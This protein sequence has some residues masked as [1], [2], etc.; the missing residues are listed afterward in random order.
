LVTIH[1]GAV[2]YRNENWKLVCEPRIDRS[3]L[4][5]WDL[6]Q[7]PEDWGELNQ[8]AR[9][10]RSREMTAN[11]R[12]KEVTFWARV[13]NMYQSPFSQTVDLVLESPADYTPE[14]YTFMMSREA[15]AEVS[16]KAALEQLAAIPAT[17]PMIATGKIESCN[18]GFA[19]AA[20]VRLTGVRPLS[21]TRDAGL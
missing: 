14:G 21:A 17:S 19:K 9:A 18:P 7:E 2:P 1:V 6:C 12:G 10:K 4:A 20:T 5:F 3:L 16:A 15:S 8:L 11:L 13:K